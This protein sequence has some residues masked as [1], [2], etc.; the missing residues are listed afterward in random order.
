MVR[1]LLGA[2]VHHHD[3]RPD[4]LLV[5]DGR[6]RVVDFHLSELTA[7]ACALGAQCSDRE[8]LRVMQPLL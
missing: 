8:F 2:G 1:A 5:L 4:N 6:L 7:G 3:I